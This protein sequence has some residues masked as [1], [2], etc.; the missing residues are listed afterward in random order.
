MKV[1]Y[2][3]KKPSRRVFHIDICN[4][5]PKIWKLGKL[6]ILQVLHIFS[7]YPASQPLLH[8]PSKWL[9]AKLS[10]QCPE[11]CCLHLIP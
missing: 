2:G 9:Q 1:A 4:K 8:V 5:Y 10:K 7:T 6:N 3:I 11:Q